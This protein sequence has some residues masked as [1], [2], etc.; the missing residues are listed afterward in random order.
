VVFV[1]LLIVFV[2]VSGVFNQI[3]AGQNQP[4]YSS[5]SHD[6]R[7]VSLLFDTLRHM[8]FSVNVLHQPINSELSSDRIVFVVHPPWLTE[9]VVEDVLEWVRWGGRLLFLEDGITMDMRLLGEEYLEYGNFRWYSIGLGEII[10]GNAHSILNINLMEDASH[11][12][13]LA[14]VLRNWGAGNIYFA[15]YYHGFGFTEGLF[16]QLPRWL[17][18]LSFQIMIATVAVVLHF[19]KRFGKPIPLY[20]HI[21]REE[22]EQ[23]L[24]LARLY[25][26]ADKKGL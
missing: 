26:M 15:E 1:I 9:T 18:L 3:F 6:E 19:G 11:G 17:Q 8:G 2:I 25:K 13:S 24:S 14:F 22:N 7:G 12:E 4:D 20:E 23:V 10:T 16:D 21:E 5:F